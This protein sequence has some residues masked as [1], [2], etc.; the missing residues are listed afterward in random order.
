MLAHL[1]ATHPTVTQQRGPLLGCMRM[2]ERRE[3][4]SRVGGRLVLVQGE[5]LERRCECSR[6]RGGARS[7]LIVDKRHN[8]PRP[9]GGGSVS[10][11]PRH[12]LAHWRIDLREPLEL[13]ERDEDG[14]TSAEAIVQVR[15][16]RHRD[17][18]DDLELQRVP[19]RQL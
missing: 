16:Q 3:S 11:V 4:R 9:R 5:C 2:Q 8:R 17:D 18:V 13:V 1:L 6:T 10:D 15:R 12:V 7:A 19:G 14:A